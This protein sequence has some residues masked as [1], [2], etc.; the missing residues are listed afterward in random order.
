MKQEDQDKL[1]AA[2]MAAM[3]AFVVGMILNAIFWVT[4]M[5][6]VVAALYWWIVA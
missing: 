1:V 5:L 4:V 3:D 6:A 2:S